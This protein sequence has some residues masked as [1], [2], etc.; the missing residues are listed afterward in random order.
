MGSGRGLYDAVALSTQIYQG[1]K[2]AEI[3][4][5]L[6]RQLSI[7]MQQA[8]QVEKAALGRR[9]LIQVE[10]DIKHARDVFEKYPYYVFSYLLSHNAEIEHSGIARDYFLET[11]DMRYAIEIRTKLNQ[12]ISEYREKIPDVEDIA[13]QIKSTQTALHNEVVLARIQDGVDAY[14]FVK[15]NTKNQEKISQAKKDAEGPSAKAEERRKKFSTPVWFF[16]VASLFLL[17][18]MGATPTVSFGSPCLL[19]FL[20]TLLTAKRAIPHELKVLDEKLKSKNQ[21]YEETLEQFGATNIDELRDLPES[22]N[23]FLLKYLPTDEKFVF[24]Q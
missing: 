4:N 11:E 18:S 14:D 9:Y 10:Q 20:F 5:V 7:S 15:S 17:L 19:L 12:E 21:L 2:Q 16:S 23:N 6:N 3:S 22:W 1:Q 8:N 24:N 13:N